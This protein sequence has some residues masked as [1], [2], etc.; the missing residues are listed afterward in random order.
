MY[1]DSTNRFRLCLGKDVGQKFLK[2]NVQKCLSLK[3]KFGSVILPLA[4]KDFGCESEASSTDL[5]GTLSFILKQDGTV[6]I[7]N[8]GYKLA[9]VYEDA[10]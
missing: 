4:L 9:F 8:K 7:I 1:A 5:Y 10:A 6:H 3:K 2:T